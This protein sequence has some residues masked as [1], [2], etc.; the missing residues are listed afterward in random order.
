MRSNENR[1]FAQFLLE[2]GNFLKKPVS[3]DD[4]CRTHE[5]D[6]DKALAAPRLPS[7]RLKHQVG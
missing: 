5:H 4:E 2:P 1:F 7:A 6:K 3:T